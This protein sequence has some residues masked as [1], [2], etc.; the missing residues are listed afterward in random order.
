MVSAVEFEIRNSIDEYKNFIVE[1]GA[2]SG[3]TWSL[4]QALSYI[5][6]NKANIFERENKK[7]VCITYTNIAKDEIIHRIKSN[8]IVQVNT[9]HEFLWSVIKPFQAEMRFELINYYE[10]KIEKPDKNYDDYSSIIQQLIEFRPSIKYQEYKVHKDGIITHGDVLWIFSSM[11]SK[12]TILK[13]IIED[14]FPIIFIDEYQDSDTK[15][16]DSLL[17]T[18]LASEKIVFGFFGDHYQKIYDNSIGQVNTNKYNLK[19][20]KKNENYRC[21]TEVINILNELRY[22]I[23]QVAMGE[24]KKGKCKFYYLPN[25]NEIEDVFKKRIESDFFGLEIS[26]FK[27]LY[28]VNKKI[29]IVNNYL[30]LYQLYDSKKRYSDKYKKKDYILK[31]SA[32]RDCDYANLLYE[33]H[34]L[35][36]LFRDDR[37]QDLLKKVALNVTNKRD[38]DEINSKLKKL[39][40][41]RKKATIG[42]VFEDVI[43]NK[44][45]KVKQDTVKELLEETEE[46]TRILKDIKYQEFENLYNTLQDD[47][48]F[49]TQHGTKGSEFD[50]V[51]CFIDDGEWRN[52]SIED[53]LIN[54]P[55]PRK[56]RIIERTRNLFYVVCSRAKYNLAIVCKSSLSVDAQN[57][58]KNIF[59]ESNFITREGLENIDIREGIFN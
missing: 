50:S 24:E 56:Q 18:F 59:G 5:I 4:V 52:Y 31:N 42:E 7:V 40:E 22:D 44:V 36:K 43:T 19:S 58:V 11:L 38:L 54:N 15:M 46:F 41:L 14:S 26:N 47:S 25:F 8:Q 30:K 48:M 39:V 6:E 10:R 12:Y 32:N 29:A 51:L 35:I 20:I 17:T 33:I 2:G 9:I 53:Y 34:N 27:K 16:I 28:L 37:A 45:I 3:K 57:N 49:S 21:S 23:K 55:D 13:K 1:A